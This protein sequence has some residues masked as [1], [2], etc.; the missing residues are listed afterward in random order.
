MAVEKQSFSDRVATELIEQI[1]Q[2]TAPWQK[3][4]DGRD[5]QAPVNAITGKPYRGANNVW[6]S[7]MQPSDDNR[8][9]TY[10]Q[11][12]SIGCTGQA[13]QDTFI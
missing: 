3:P 13:A 5:L 8:W 11:A 1:K 10:N 12:E 2:G 9:L 6:L 4:W 7:M